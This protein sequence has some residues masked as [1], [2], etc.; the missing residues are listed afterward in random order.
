MVDGAELT[1]QNK[2]NAVRVMIEQLASQGAG[3][4][5]SEFV[6]VLP[7]SKLRVLEHEAVRKAAVRR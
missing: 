2:R 5:L 7:N 4:S 6:N 3:A 1:D